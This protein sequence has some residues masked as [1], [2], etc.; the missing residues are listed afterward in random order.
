MKQLIK[1]ENIEC[2]ENYIS[3]SLTSHSEIKKINIYEIKLLPKSLRKFYSHYGILGS[4][5]PV[6]G[7]IKYFADIENIFFNSLLKQ[8]KKNY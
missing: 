3:F 7:N 5:F 4:Y 1:T 8:S 2:D 6:Q